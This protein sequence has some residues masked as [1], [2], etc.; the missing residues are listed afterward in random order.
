PP[1]V[2]P[3]DVSQ[4]I[5]LRE[6]PALETLSWVNR[7]KLSDDGNDL[8]IEHERERFPVGTGQPNKD[9]DRCFTPLGDEGHCKF[10]H[11]C[12]Q[13]DFQYDFTIFQTFS[14]F[15][16]HR[17]VTYW[18]VC[19]SNEPP[20][21]TVSPPDVSQTITRKQNNCTAQ[22]FS[23]S[24]RRSCGIPLEERQLPPEEEENLFTKITL[25]EKS[26][27]KVWAWVAA[28]INLTDRKPFCGA[29]LVSSRHV[30]TAAHCV[31]FKSRIDYMVRLGEHDFNQTGVLSNPIDYQVT[32]TTTHDK[33]RRSGITDDIAILTL[34]E[35]TD[36]NCA[37]WRI[38]LPS[39]VLSGER[40][41]EW[42][43]LGNSLAWVVGWGR[44][45]QGGQASSVLLEI[46]VRIWTDK[47]CAEAY[48]EYAVNPPRFICAGDQSKDSCSGDSGGPLMMQKK[49]HWH[50][51]GVV[52]AGEGCGRKGKPGI[53]TRVDFYGPFIES[54]IFDSF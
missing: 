9:F 36:F 39:F 10:L 35:P 24:G 25:G 48:P 14:C 40:Q 28:L 7:L 42:S 32:K 16:K 49:G 23:G 22:R 47:E 50:L 8:E 18:G 11:Y 31:A 3:P 52:S 6:N 27:P 45:S 46:K 30:I 54:V 17:D 38:C 19:C 53:Y 13:K 4:T 5:L 2:S 37:I 15:I 1:D 43:D 20:P 51:I 34:H 26:K 21:A 44:T 33:Y 29:T 41:S 12:V